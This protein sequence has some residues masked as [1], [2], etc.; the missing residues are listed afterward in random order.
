[1]G[2]NGYTLVEFVVVALL[3]V[4]AAAVVIPNLT[5]ARHG[6]LDLAA[7][8]VTSALIYARNEAMRTG[9]WR[10]VDFGVGGTDQVRVYR[11]DGSASAI[12][13][14]RNPTDLKLYQFDLKTLPFAGGIRIGTAYFRYVDSPDFNRATVDFN[15]RGLPVVAY[16][17]LGVGIESVAVAPPDA[18]AG[19]FLTLSDGTLTR[20][21]TINPVTGRITTN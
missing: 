16:L 1:M 9:L 18:R 21:V 20:T 3:L 14:E 12:F 11:R 4:I 15:A 8:E 2:K 7:E 5:T 13:D 19:L 10:G 17:L 6:K